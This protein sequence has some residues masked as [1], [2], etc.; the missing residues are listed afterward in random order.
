[1][2]VRL[3]TFAVF[4][5]AFTV[6]M[7]HEAHAYING[8]FK[9]ERE[10]REYYRRQRDERASQAAAQLGVLNAAITR[11]PEDAVAYY[12]RAKH[13]TE[14]SH[15]NQR[16]ALADFDAAI[17]LKP[18]FTQ[19]LSRR[20]AVHAAVKDYVRSAAD[21][22]EALRQDSKA[23][24]I[25]LRLAALYYASPDESVRDLV[26]S[27]QLVEELVASGEKPVAAHLDLLAATCAELGDFDSA[28]K[29]ETK[30]LQGQPAS[31]AAQFGRIESYK[32]GEFAADL[33]SRLA[34]SLALDPTFSR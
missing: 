19:A 24:D 28:V 21:L 9:S 32:R 3:T 14:H 34:D 31:V 26:K 20:A 25:K 18:D 33:R 27:R 10:S 17:Q 16:L 4:L 30:R 22:T 5:T 15:L 6:F 12:Q 23:V 29:W 7:P 1:M 2:T 8:G 11:D 13:H